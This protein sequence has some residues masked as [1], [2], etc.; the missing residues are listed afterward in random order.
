MGILSRLKL[1]LGH[2][3]E[4]VKEKKSSGEIT[5][6]RKETPEKILEAKIKPIKIPTI[7]DIG[8]KL[9]MIS[10][11]LVNIKHEMVTKAWLRAEYDEG[12]EII[13]K[14]EIIDKK[15]DDLRDLITIP[16]YPE[17]KVNERATL[18]KTVET[19][20]TD[21][22]LDVISEKGKITYGELRKSIDI[23]DP[24]LSKYLKRLLKEG[25]IRKEKQGRFIYYSVL[26]SQNFLT[27]RERDFQE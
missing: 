19:S 8:E 1:L 4:R 12:K 3:K 10:S 18:E 13:K 25:K 22:I 15:L 16:Y 26:T 2:E 6:Y 23:S 5:V 27:Q 17:Q 20:L 14:L 11:A 21:K 24:T 9:G 7:V